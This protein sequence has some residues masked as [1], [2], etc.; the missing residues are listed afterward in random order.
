ML[1][2]ELKNQICDDVKAK[3]IRKFFSP[4]EINVVKCHLVVI[5]AYCYFVVSW[6]WI[7]FARYGPKDNNKKKKKKKKK[8]MSIE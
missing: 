8:K 3:Y 6:M 2:Q 1:H 7:K 5:N 4:C